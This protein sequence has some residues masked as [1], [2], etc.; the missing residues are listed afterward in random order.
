VKCYA[1]YTNGGRGEI[2]EEGRNKKTV[3]NSMRI[4]ARGK[5]EVLKRCIAGREVTDSEIRLQ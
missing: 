1:E 5:K 3:K 4:K 2:P